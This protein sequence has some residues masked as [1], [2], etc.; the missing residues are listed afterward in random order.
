MD[1]ARGS[2]GSMLL[3]EQGM[4]NWKHTGCGYFVSA[5]FSRIDRRSL[6]V[7]RNKLYAR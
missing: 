5:D 1:P 2:E 3:Q 7:K 6:M 4:R